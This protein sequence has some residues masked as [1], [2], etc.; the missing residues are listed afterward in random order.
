MIKYL[1]FI[2]NTWGKFLYWT[3]AHLGLLRKDTA[4]CISGADWMIF[5]ANDTKKWTITNEK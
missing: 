2:N 3:M 4:Y 5:F 1:S